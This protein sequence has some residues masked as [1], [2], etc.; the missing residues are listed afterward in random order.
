MTEGNDKTTPSYPQCVDSRPVDR[1]GWETLVR[2]A[3][4]DSRRDRKTK[5][6]NKGTWREKT[7]AT[8]GSGRYGFQQINAGNLARWGSLWS[9]AP[10]LNQTNDAR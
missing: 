6:G 4:E 8:S 2:T 9:E 10:R 1:P 7:G 5:L 3:D